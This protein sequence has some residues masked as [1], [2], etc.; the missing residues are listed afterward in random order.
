MTLKELVANRMEVLGLS[1]R[2]FTRLLGIRNPNKA[3]AF[4][5]RA[6]ADDMKGMVHMRH[7]IANALQVPVFEVEN[8]IQASKQADFQRHDAEY[9]AIFKPHAMLTTTY[10]VPQPIHA[11]LLTGAPEKLRIE[12]PA[13]LPKV[14]WPQ[15]VADQ[16]PDGLPG[17]GWVTG[18]AINYSPDHAVYFDR[19]AN[20]Y[21]VRN[22][23]YRR[24][25]G[26]MYGISPALFGGHR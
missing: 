17:F 24:G 22:A 10:S 16:L 26:G 3:R 1:D 14:R 9:R 2:D 25:H 15:F 19:E 21:Q 8:A 5:E 20:P 12:I 4:I 7:Q 18:F 23:A 11:A 6:Q 13:D